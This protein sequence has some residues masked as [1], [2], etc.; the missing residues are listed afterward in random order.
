MFYVLMLRENVKE[1]YHTLQHPE[2]EYTPA[3]REE[4]RLEKIMDTRDMQ[5][6]DEMAH[7]RKS[8]S[9]DGLPGRQR[10]NAKRRSEPSNQSSLKT[11]GCKNVNTV[12]T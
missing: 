8:N 7:P 10:G 9:R 12:L 5:L 1:P 3:V 2:V 6:R 4:I 11:L